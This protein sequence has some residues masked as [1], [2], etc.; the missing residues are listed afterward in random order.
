MRKGRILSE[1]LAEMDEFPPLVAQLVGVGEST[2]RLE[3]LLEKV[4]QFYTRE[5]NDMVDNLVNLL[6]PVLMIIIGVVVAVLFAS[7]LLPI[8]GLVQSF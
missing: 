3:Q 1:A 4:R 2:G 6:Q 7:I 8:Y 5:V